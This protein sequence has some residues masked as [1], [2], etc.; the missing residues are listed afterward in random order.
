MGLFSCVRKVWSWVLWVHYGAFLLVSGIHLNW[1]LGHAMA[2]D[3]MFVVY[4][5]GMASVVGWS[6][7]LLFPA[8]PSYITRKRV[9]WVVEGVLIFYA[10]AQVSPYIS[11]EAQEEAVEWMTEQI[12]D[13]EFFLAGYNLWRLFGSTSAIT[14]V[15]TDALA[16]HVQVAREVA[17]VCGDSSHPF[18]QHLAKAAMVEEMTALVLMEYIAAYT[19]TVYVMAKNTMRAYE[20]GD[21]AAIDRSLQMFLKAGENDPPSVNPDVLAGL[22]GKPWVG[23]DVSPEYQL[24]RD[25][26]M[27]VVVEHMS[28]S[29][30][31]LAKNTSAVALAENLRKNYQVSIRP[32]TET[33]AGHV[34]TL[35][36]NP[37]C[38]GRIP[39]SGWARHTTDYLRAKVRDLEGLYWNHTR[40]LASLSHPPPATSP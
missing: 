10:I 8:L 26:P 15:D 19:Q 27:L 32:R 34:Q 20:H 18:V 28:A 1:T 36:R 2:E 39:G 24:A 7:L 12:R 31:Q 17:R 16:N 30:E 11:R 35:A 38:V 14:E 21:C 33:H 23:I 29:L 4:L 37:K 40:A 3:P 22:L 9:W 5:A 13:L 6:S 25:F